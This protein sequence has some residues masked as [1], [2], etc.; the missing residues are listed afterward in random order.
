MKV[1]VLPLASGTSH[2]SRHFC[3]VIT[4]KWLPV[5]KSYSRKAL[6]VSSLCESYPVAHLHILEAK[7]DPLKQ[8]GH[9]KHYWLP[10]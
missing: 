4:W 10:Q 1:V 9:S 7:M 3:W 8:S 6:L 5:I 2:T